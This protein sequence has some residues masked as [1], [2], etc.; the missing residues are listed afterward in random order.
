MIRRPEL[1]PGG[2]T[3]AFVGR[4]ALLGAYRGEIPS[5]FFAPQKVTPFKHEDLEPGRGERAQQCSAD[6]NRSDDDQLTALTF[7][8]GFVAMASAAAQ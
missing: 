2:I 5:R 8:R 1:V 3:P 4:V 6:G 7:A